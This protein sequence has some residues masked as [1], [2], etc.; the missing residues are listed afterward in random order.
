MIRSQSPATAI[1]PDLT[2]PVVEEPERE[3]LLKECATKK[4]AT[5]LGKTNANNLCQQLSLTG[6]RPAQ[7]RAGAGTSSSG[8][9]S[10]N[11]LPEEPLT[12]A[13]IS[14]MS[15]AAI[16]KCL[17]I[18]SKQN[19]DK[20]RKN[21]LNSS[22]TTFVKNLAEDK[23]IEVVLHLKL[24]RRSQIRTRCRGSLIK[25][26]LEHKDQQAQIR[27]ML[28][29]RRPVDDEQSAEAMNVDVE[30]VDTDEKRV[31]AGE[32]NSPR[33]DS[34]PADTDMPDCVK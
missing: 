27:D 22:I 20:L 26:Y 21:L 32:T 28:R 31:A 1:F 24:P 23:V 19:L 10:Y 11:S 3:T 6:S 25:Y 34:H 13:A 16:L 33:S 2:L 9:S 8:V 29:D 30:E 7:D 4:A 12:E 18:E 5:R 14:G 17:G 15:R